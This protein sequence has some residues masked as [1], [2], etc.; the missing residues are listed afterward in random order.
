MQQPVEMERKEKASSSLSVFFL[1]FIKKN[2]VL[3]A[4]SVQSRYFTQMIIMPRGCNTSLLLATLEHNGI[5]INGRSRIER[6]PDMEKWAYLS[7]T[8]HLNMQG[9]WH[10]PNP[11]ALRTA[12]AHQPDT[13][14]GIDTRTTSYTHTQ[15]HTQTHTLTTQITSTY[16]KMRMN[17]TA[18]KCYMMIYEKSSLVAHQCPS[19][20]LHLLP[21][22]VVFVSGLSLP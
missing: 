18:T 6:C 11:P 4:S 8:R 21:R 14:R 10:N 17:T 19:L 5:I 20:L 7:S 3:K 1:F 15:I 16:S 22:I 9:E 13:L 2:V 12:H